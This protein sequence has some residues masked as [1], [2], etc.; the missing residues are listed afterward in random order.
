[1]RHHLGR[2][3]GSLRFEPTPVRVRAEVAGAVVVDTRDALLVWEPRRLIPEY[4]VPAADLVA[5][6]SPVDP[7]PEP[8]DLTALPSM[9]GPGGF[10]THTC[11]GTV[12]DVGDLPAAG[13]VPDDPDLGGRVLL[14][15]AAFD[16]WLAEDEQLVGHVHD[17]FKRIEVLRSTR[18]V[19]VRLDGQVL[20][21][22][23]RPLA[24]LETHLPVRWYLPPSDVRMDLLT[25]SETRSTCAYKGFASYLSL[26]DG[27]SAGRDLAWF[28][29]APRHDAEQVRDYVCFWSERTDLLLDG[30]LQERPVTPWSRPEEQSAADPER[31]EFG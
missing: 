4:A 14:D 30:V 13:F 3:T 28:Y 24:L 8:A 11:P 23:S 6:T 17:P 31:L 7:Q 16:R 26:A 2:A 10:G 29:P 15:F 5:G 22:S 12:V 9:L 19:E 27:S 25:S 1:M 20:A 21:A 18:S